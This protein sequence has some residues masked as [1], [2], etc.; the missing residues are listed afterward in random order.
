MQQPTAPQGD[1]ADRLRRVMGPPRRRRAGPPPP[2]TLAFAAAML[3]MAIVQFT[4]GGYAWRDGEL[5]TPLIDWALGAKVPSLIAHGEYWRLVTANFLHASW[6]H[7]VVNLLGLYALGRIIEGFYGSARTFVLF[8]LTA[9]AGA[10]VSYLLNPVVS[11]GAS[12]GIMGLMGALVWHN[13]KYR[14]YLPARL[15]YVYP[16][17]LAL[18]IFQFVLDQI[19]PEV[20]A[21]AH[22]GGFLAGFC[23]AMLLESRLTGEG[24]GERDW[25]PLPTALA[26]AIGLLVYGGLGL[27]L[28]LPRSMPL[29][30]AGK[31]DDVAQRA[32]L[33]RGVVAERPYFV[34]AQ[35]ELV[36]QLVNQGKVGDAVREYQT[37][38]AA[39]P[40]LTETHLGK[41]VLHGLVSGH[42]I[43]AMALD[44]QGRLDV[45]LATFQQ[46]LKLDPVPRDAAL[47]RNGYAWLLVDRLQGDLNVAEQYAVR[48]NEDHPDYPAYL[49]TL[50]WIYYKQGRLEKALSKQ[51]QAVEQAEKEPQDLNT[52][53]LA[54][55]YYHLGAIYERMGK[56]ND[57][58]GFYTKALEKRPGYP[59]AQAGLGRVSD[60]D[61]QPTR[62]SY[63]PTGTM[64]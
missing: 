3:L 26:T 8:V 51:L 59:E 1:S 34:E 56:E 27:A 63:P 48:A 11:L 40:T 2:V 61:D 64:I 7:L 18:V 16:L 50:A 45:A 29:L 37:A 19:Q 42:M 4:A 31:D 49:D 28:A 54:E 60:P 53:G 52:E 21:S 20:D 22:L 62:P 58:K 35:L 17:L 47:L 13:W 41:Q 24:Q 10:A 30:R 36:I 44:R 39:F 15:N 55:V 12:T 23:L 5:A 57:A 33:I 14:D 6:L 25:L 38:L 46:A 32:A 9:V 43:M